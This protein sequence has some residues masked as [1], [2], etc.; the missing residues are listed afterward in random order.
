MSAEIEK[1]AKKIGGETLKHYRE[2]YPQEYQHLAPHLWQP[3]PRNTRPQS[4]FSPWRADVTADSA[5]SSSSS[6]SDSEYVVDEQHRLNE[7]YTRLQDNYSV[8]SS[9]DRELEEYKRPSKAS[10][11]INTQMEP[12]EQIIDTKAKS[13]P[14]KN[15]AVAVQSK[16]VRQ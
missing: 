4:R 16:R 13:R 15:P 2:K 8:D 6:G 9:E 3:S 12:P 1:I 10:A 5:T 7:F 14:K 11:A